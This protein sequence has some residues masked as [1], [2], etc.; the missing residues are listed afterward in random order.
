MLITLKGPQALSAFRGDRLLQ[1][2]KAICP[3]LVGI[4]GGF[5]HLVELSRP[6]Q[7]EEETRLR[8]ILDY[9]EAPA[10]V[11]QGFDV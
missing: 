6:L 3:R 10:E 1:D 8:T 7:S 9:G 4:H 5:E 11:P 2:L